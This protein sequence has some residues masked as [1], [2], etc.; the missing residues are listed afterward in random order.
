[1]ALTSSEPDEY[2]LEGCTAC[3]LCHQVR[4]R[5]PRCCSVDHVTLIGRL[6]ASRSA[7]DGL[8]LLQ[9][10]S[11][12]LTACHVQTLPQCHHIATLKQTPPDAC[13]N[14][15][16]R[17]GMFGRDW[18]GCSHLLVAHQSYIS[19]ILDQAHPLSM[20]SISGMWASQPAPNERLA[21]ELVESRFS[22]LGQHYL[23]MYSLARDS[24]YTQHVMSCRSQ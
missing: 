9:A 1:M 10:Y 18:M 17:H 21:T 19:F 24:T 13:C 15:R 2:V 3:T 8:V 11:N 7:F 23:L 22:Y 16:S 14:R 20:M 5:M 4:E 6:G 12:L